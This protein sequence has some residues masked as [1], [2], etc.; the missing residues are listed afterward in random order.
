MTFSSMTH[1]TWRPQWWPM[2]GGDACSATGRAPRRLAKPGRGLA[3]GADEIPLR[4]RS[5]IHIFERIHR[6]HLRLS[7]IQGI[8]RVISN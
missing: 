4:G 7:T 5:A 1:V 2:A 3:Q 8:L 6:R